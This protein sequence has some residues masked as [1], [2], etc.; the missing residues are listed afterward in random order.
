MELFVHP[1]ANALFSVFSACFCIH[2]SREMAYSLGRNRPLDR[3]FPLD[4]YGDGGLLKK[5]TS[6]VAPA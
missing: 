5:G 2:L 6:G 4:G 3:N 1:Y